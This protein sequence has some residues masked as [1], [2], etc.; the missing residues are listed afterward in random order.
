M[1]LEDK[2]I[3]HKLVDKANSPAAGGE[4]TYYDPTKK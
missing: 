3:L 2:A 4:Y 1:S